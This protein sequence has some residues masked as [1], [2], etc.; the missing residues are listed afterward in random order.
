M[1]RIVSWFSCGAASAVA[2]K[3]ALR[4]YPRN[5]VRV[6][7]CNTMASEHPDNLRFFR[8]VEDW[9]GVKITVIS[10]NK[11]RKV[12][13][14]F[15]SRQYMSGPMGAP[16][17]VEM[18]KLPRFEFQQGDDVHVFGFTA[19]EEKRIADFEER[20]PE[21]YLHWVLRDKDISKQDCYRILQ[22]AGIELPAMYRLGYQNNNC[23]GCVKATSPAYWNKIRKDFPK[24]FRERAK[25]SRQIGCKLTRVKGKRIFLDE[26]PEGDFGRYKLED[27]SCGQECGVPSKKK[28]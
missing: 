21:L 14:V 2:A 10:S 16:C 26:L 11:F 12:E 20:N 28:S 9:L 13:E 18:K 17:T 23:I 1:R 8:E 4:C 19:D 6:V 15:A 5:V 24:V 27:I 3:C 25:Q 7:Y 22:D